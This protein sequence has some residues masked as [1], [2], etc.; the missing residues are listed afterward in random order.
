[1]MK[2]LDSKRQWLTPCD[3]I[4]LHPVL[5][6]NG[7][8]QIVLDVLDLWLQCAENSLAKVQSV[9]EILVRSGASKVNIW[10]FPSECRFV[11]PEEVLSSISL[12]GQGS[13]VL[14]IIG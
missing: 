9:Y 8:L 1:M 13:S 4:C 14:C 12:G 3:Q 2:P 7:S 10:E 11:I 5:T 6:C